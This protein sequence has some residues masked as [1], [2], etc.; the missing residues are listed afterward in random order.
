MA[1]RQGNGLTI[2]CP[3]WTCDEG[4]LCPHA[5]KVALATNRV[6]ALRGNESAD[7]VVIATNALGPLTGALGRQIDV[8]QLT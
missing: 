1:M 5:V 3:E 2:V 4:K 8:D 7:S 6:G